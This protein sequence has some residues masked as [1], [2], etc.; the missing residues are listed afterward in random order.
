MKKISKNKMHEQ[1]PDNTFDNIDTII[2]DLDGTFIKKDSSFAI[3]KRLIKHDPG[4]FFQAIFIYFAHGEARVKEYVQLHGRFGS[5][6]CV[7]E[8]LLRYL[9][10]QKGKK[11]LVLATGAN[12]A[13]AQEINHE[14][15]LFDDVIASDADNNCIGVNKLKKIRESYSKFMYIGDHWY[16]C[17]IWFEADA[18]GV[19]SPSPALLDLLQKHGKEHGK[20]VM[21]FS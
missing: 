2:I 16:D 3:W 1:T 5:S 14:Y 4:A 8:K 18:I 17:P 9:I 15:Q 6:H 11:K 21:V 19:V 7:N 13:V 10:E 20:R 12:I